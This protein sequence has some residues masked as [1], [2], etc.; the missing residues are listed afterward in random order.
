MANKFIDKVKE[1]EGSKH[2]ESYS[3]QISKNGYHIKT[4]I[5]LFNKYVE[6]N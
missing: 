6:E 5:G 3:Y 2:L 1:L 4:L